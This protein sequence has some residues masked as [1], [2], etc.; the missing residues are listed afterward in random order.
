MIFNEIKCHVNTALGLVGGCIPPCVRACICRFLKSSLQRSKLPW[1][2][3][4]TTFMSL[5]YLARLASIIAGLTIVAN[6]AIATGPRFWE[7][8]GHL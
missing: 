5:F 8:R 4:K 2:F 6:V 1:S 7:P 3:N